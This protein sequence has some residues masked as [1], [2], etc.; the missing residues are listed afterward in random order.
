MNSELIIYQTEDGNTKVNLKAIDGTVWL[1]QKEI[2]VLFDRDIRTIN[3]HLKTIF[4]DNELLENSVIRKFRITAVDGKSY[5]TAHYNLDAILAVGYR[6]RSA[7]GVQFR[8]WATTLLKDY[9]IKGFA[10]DDMRLK[11]VTQ[12]DYFDEWLARIR[13]I[14]ASEKRFYQKIK[15]LY[16]TA[17]DYNKNSSQAKLFFKKVQNKMLWTV[18]G[19]TAAEIVANRSNHKLPNMGLTSWTGSK[20]RKMDVDIAKNYLS[21]EEVEELNRIVTMYLDYA[22]DQ[23]KKRKSITMAEW[24][25]KLDAFLNFNER[26]ILT[27]AGKIRANVAKQLAEDRYDLFDKH[28]Q[29]EELKQANNDDLK[30]LEEISKELNKGDRHG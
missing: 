25:I 27:H 5:D 23:A 28:R 20:V 7:R 9:L 13:E 12:W 24:S 26:K 19:N 4:A 21:Q 22:E 6:V 10:M 16:I 18:T 1:T 3:E 11:Q 15:D 17:V 30:E 8:K 29:N 2:A 14:R